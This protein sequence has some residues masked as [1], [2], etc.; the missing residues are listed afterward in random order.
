MSVY[1]KFNSELNYSYVDFD[2]L[3][4]SVTDLKKAILH[5]KRLGKSADFDLLVSFQPLN[6]RES[7]SVC[8]NQSIPAFFFIFLLRRYQML[9]QKRNTRMNNALFRRTQV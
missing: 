5:Q 4:I 8:A 3:H 7:S 1:Y 9:K 2:G 6:E